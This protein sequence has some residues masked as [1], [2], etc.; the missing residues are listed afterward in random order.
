MPIQLAGR[1][2]L[3]DVTCAKAVVTPMMAVAIAVSI[4]ATA[5]VTTAIGYYVLVVAVRR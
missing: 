1:P 3:A 4:F 2:S 5:T